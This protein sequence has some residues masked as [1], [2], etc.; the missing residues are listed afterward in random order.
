LMVETGLR[1]GGKSLYAAGLSS[2]D[3]QSLAIRGMI[4]LERG[5]IFTSMILAAIGVALIERR[6]AQ[7]GAW[8]AA[9][10]LLSAFGI[11]HAY[12]L[13]SGGVTSRFGWMA[14]PDFFV[15][16][17]LLAVLFFLIGILARNGAR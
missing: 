1:A 2:F 8:A 6:F 11:I 3:Q 17:L 14:A 5:F 9:A 16:Y 10:A 7:A 15:A 13:T 12:N 4:S